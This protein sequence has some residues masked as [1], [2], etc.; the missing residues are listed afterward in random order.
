MLQVARL[1]ATSTTLLAG[2]I[3][4]ITLPADSYQQR[5]CMSPILQS[6]KLSPLRRVVDT[7]NHGHD[8]L[9]SAGIDFHCNNNS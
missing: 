6:P 2:T 4:R 3:I 1:S 8:I 7:F 9:S 5:V